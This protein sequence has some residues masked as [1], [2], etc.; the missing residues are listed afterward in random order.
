MIRKALFAILLSGGLASV[1]ATLITGSVEMNGYARLN[2]TTLGNATG[3]IG[4]TGVEV[5][6]T[7]TEAFE[8]AIG[9]AVDFSAFNWSP[10]SAPLLLWEFEHAGWTYSFSLD[11]L[12]V[13]SQSANFLDLSG[14]GRLNI[15][16]LG[17]D[18]EETFGDW[19]FQITSSSG[20]SPTS[21]FMFQS[22]TSA[23]SNV[24]DGGSTVAVLGLA[25]IG[26]AAFGRKFVRSE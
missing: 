8:P 16:G 13:V 14:Q 18:Y 22:S 3:V 25:M 10:S 4:F 23:A 12:S 21:R 7:S 5:A 1:Q 11:S 15:V 9:A 19:T 17:S 20:K 24:P 26:L 2:N 6:E